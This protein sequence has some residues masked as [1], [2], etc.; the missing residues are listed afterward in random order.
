LSAHPFR[1]PKKFVAT[2]LGLVIAALVF[3]VVKLLIYVAMAQGHFDSAMCQWDCNWYLRIAR[4]G[5]DT[6][7]FLVGAEHQADWAF[8]PLYPAL[9]KAWGY[10]IGEPLEVAG[11]VISTA[12]FVAF[13]VIG[14]HYRVASRGASSPLIWLLLLMTWPYSF[15]FHAAYTEALYA[16][17]SVGILSFLL[18]GRLL[19]AG[20]ASAFL[21]ATRPNGILVAAWI[22]LK[23]LGEA[24][25]AG[26]A[27]GVVRALIP[28]AIAPLGLIAFMALLYIRTGDPLAFQHV[29]SGWHHEMSNP[30]RVLWDGFATLDLRHGRVGPSYLAGWAVLGLIAA[31]WLGW[32]GLSA[33]AWLCGSTV[34]LALMS[35]NLWSMPRYVA[36][37]PFFLLAVADVIERIP[38]PAVRL[39]I[40]I[41]F[42]A[43]QIFFVLAWYRG[44]SFLP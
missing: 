43:V 41:L 31:V 3:T 25:K 5:Y 13:A 36:A 24:R 39:V 34:I 20:I 9:L 6:A 7:T 28:A 2:S 42:S 40:F 30:L 22:G 16:A 32:R 17:L 14:Q 44:A 8:F 37:N 1:I 15:Y 38:K 26:T 33:E 10:V 11:I 21:T 35:G 27:G 12:A 19:W 23:A 4:R 18:S 29:Q